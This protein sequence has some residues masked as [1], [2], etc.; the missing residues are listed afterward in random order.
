MTRRPEETVLYQ[1]VAENLESFLDG[2]RRMAGTAAHRVD[3][4]LPLAP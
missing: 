1:V 2:G 3:R 4:V